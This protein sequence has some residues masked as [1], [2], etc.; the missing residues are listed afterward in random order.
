MDPWCY[1]TSE[2]TWRNLREV[3]LASG[4]EMY[5]F[6]G[7]AKLYCWARL[8]SVCTGSVVR[9]LIFAYMGPTLVKKK[10]NSFWRLH[11]LN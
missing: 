5:W 1:Q 11:S 6:E 8:R 4:S 10:G 2:V 3:S 7:L 9:F